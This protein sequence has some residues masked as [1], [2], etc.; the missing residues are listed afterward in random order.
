MARFFFFF[1]QDR[2][3]KTTQN[4][5]KTTKNQNHVTRTDCGAAVERGKEEGG[6]EILKMNKYGGGGPIFFQ[7]IFN[8][9]G[10]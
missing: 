9:D 8:T 5:T 1:F 10:K 6:F 2:R 7:K 4:T 3:K